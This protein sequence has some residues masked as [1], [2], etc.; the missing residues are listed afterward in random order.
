M[1]KPFSTL[2]D[3]LTPEQKLAARAKFI[4]LQIELLKT[5]EKSPH[6]EE[7]HERTPIDAPIQR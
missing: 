1:N 5:G 6:H 2:K 7:H 4:E 3:K